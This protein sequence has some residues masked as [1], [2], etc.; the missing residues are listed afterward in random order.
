MQHM[1]TQPVLT[2]LTA[3]AEDQWGLVTRQQA[4]RLGTPP[5]T[6]AR[7]TAEDGALYRIANGVYRL[8]GAPPPDHEA[9][10][11]AWLQLAP[12][13]PA[14]ERREDEG[15]VSHRSAADMYGV[16]HLPEEL[17]EFTVGKRRQSRRP[18]V[19]IHQRRM[20]DADWIILRGLPVTRPAR[21]ASDL[22]YANEDPGAVAHV[23]ADALRNVYDYPTNVADALAPHAARFGMQR[24]DGVALL[25]WMLDLVGDHQADLWISE[26]RASRGSTTEPERAPATVGGGP[27]R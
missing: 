25:K 24:H 13:V 12:N 6:M 22:L 18:D 27:L 2:R 4:T 23:I 14:W 3:T 15:V 5:R 8:G 7:L 9:L 20:T 26:A 19:R 17:H 21:I 1:A 10:R 16:G 11:A